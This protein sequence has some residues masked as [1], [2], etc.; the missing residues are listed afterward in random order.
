M[1]YGR[2][3][4]ITFDAYFDTKQARAFLKTNDERFTDADGARPG[5]HVVFAT[6]PLSA[7][8]HPAYYNRVLRAM[9]NDPDPQSLPPHIQQLGFV[10]EYDRHI[11]RR[12]EVIVQ[13]LTPS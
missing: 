3:K 4:D 6:N 13:H 12:L 9:M 5:L 8:A 7:D 11:A 2:I 10:T 1:P